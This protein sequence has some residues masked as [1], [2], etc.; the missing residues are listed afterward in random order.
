MSQSTT[1]L[2]TDHTFLHLLRCLGL[3]FDEFRTF[4]LSIAD[5][6]L[7][8]GLSIAGNLEAVS[9]IDVPLTQT[10]FAANQSVAILDNFVLAQASVPEPA[11]LSLLAL[12]LFGLGFARKRRTQ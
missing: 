11:S 12:G 10:G 1:Q 6:Q 7:A 4:T 3:A 8:G 2:S 5:A 9:F